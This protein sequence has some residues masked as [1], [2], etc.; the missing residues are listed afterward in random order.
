MD[1]RK[2]E[3]RPPG[4]A[5]PPLPPPPGATGDATP[6]PDIP[7]A[8]AAACA[9]ACFSDWRLLTRRMAQGRQTTVAF[10]FADVAHR[11][12]DPPAQAHGCDMPAPQVDSRGRQHGVSRAPVSRGDNIWLHVT[13]LDRFVEAVDISDLLLRLARPWGA[14]HCDVAGFEDAGPPYKERRPRDQGRCTHGWAL[15]RFPDECGAAEACAALSGVRVPP[16]GPLALSAARCRVQLSEH[17]QAQ[18]QAAADAAA[19]RQEEQRQHNIRQRQRRRERGTAVLEQA[20]LR[21]QPLGGGAE[22]LS[23]FA[24]LD[25]VARQSEWPGLDW[26]AVPAQC[27]PDAVLSERRQESGLPAP[28]A[29]EGAQA[30]RLR[31]KRVQVESFACALFAM[32]AK[33]R[34]AAHIIDFGAGTGGLAL[35]LAAL[36]PTHQFT[37]VDLDATS[38]GILE[39]RA[40]AAGL[41]NIRGCVSRIELFSQP[42][43]IA[44]G[45]HCCGSATDYAQLRAVAQRAAYILCPCCVGKV[46]LPQSQKHA[47]SGAGLAPELTHPRSA[48]MRTACD[49]VTFAAMS[50]AADVSHSEESGGGQQPQR[51]LR[52]SRV[53]ALNLALD[54]SHAA[55]EAGYMTACLTLFQPAIQSKNLLLVGAPQESDWGQLVAGMRASDPRPG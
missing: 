53:C 46:M 2:E 26:S 29:T 44:L 22:A 32:L 48:W 8:A 13:G 40:A 25:D 1:V 52:V 16:H 15:L 45:L 55:A 12:T 54:R 28:V 20:L 31:R 9:A 14:T 38:I 7:A 4:G 6:A 43:D 23:A 39:R 35:P 19:R 34:D 24:P 10:P 50:A 5:S 41:T 42:F 33:R 17:K 47:R 27:C 49:G 11:R 51:H 3:P 36:F 21:L 30:Q 18:V 37:A